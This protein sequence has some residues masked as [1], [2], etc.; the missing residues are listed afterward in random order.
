MS[1]T[2]SMIE[3]KRMT[4]DE[5]RREI[6]SKRSE[7]AKIRL[8]IHGQS[9]KNHAQM[10]ILR[11]NIARITM[12]YATLPETPKTETAAKKVEKETTKVTKKP[13]KVSSR[14]TKKK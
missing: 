6:A 3:L 11:R 7:Y 9:E 2:S 5:L 1:T 14:P 8:H 12:V 10:K 13:V 4:R